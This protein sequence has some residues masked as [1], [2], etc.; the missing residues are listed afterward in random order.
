MTQTIVSATSRRDDLQIA[1]D[2]GLETAAPYLR[3]KIPR[4]CITLWVDAMFCPFPADVA[5]LVEQRFRKPQ[6]TG[7]NPVVGS[8]FTF[9][10]PQNAG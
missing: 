4:A 9:S 6:V 8:G 7:S 5:Q 1:P 2:G 10:A 3:H